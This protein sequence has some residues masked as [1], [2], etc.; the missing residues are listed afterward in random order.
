MLRT[1]FVKDFAIIDGAD[2]NFTAGMSVLTGETGAGKSLL[3]DALMLLAGGRGDAGVVRHGAERAEMS[4]EFDV[5]AQT[6]ARAWLREQELDDD[7]Q[8]RLRR[9]IRADG[10]SRA[11]IN[12]RPVSLSVLREAAGFL[13]E[14]HGQHEHQ[15]LLSRK[16]QL[17]LLDAFAQHPERLDD[18][19]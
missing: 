19:Q 2:V 3:V 15:A 13:V 6:A 1:L 14:I 16:H 17:A 18:V 7:E 5:R 11:W 12:D 4:A 10:S 8:L 9:V